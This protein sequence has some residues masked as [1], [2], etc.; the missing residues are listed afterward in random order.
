[1]E[2]PREGDREVADHDVE[3]RIAFE[4][5]DLIHDV[6]VS[7]CVC[8]CDEH[9]LEVAHFA[10]RK[11]SDHIL[12]AGSPVGVLLDSAIELFHADCPFKEPCY[13]NG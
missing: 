11:R 3:R 10:S 2:R 12:H 13:T 8:S 4:L 1:M 9:S 5:L 6:I 7:V